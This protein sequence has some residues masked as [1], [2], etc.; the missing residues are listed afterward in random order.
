MNRIEI[1]KDKGQELFEPKSVHRIFN[2]SDLPDRECFAEADKVAL[3]VVTIGKNLPLEVNNLMESGEYVDGVILDAVGS[4]GVEAIADLINHQINKE[5]ERLHLEYSK[6]YSPGYC[7][8]NVKDQG[9]IFGLLPTKEIDVFLTDAY[10]MTP[11]K[12][13]SFAI[14]I[15]EGIKNSR[16]ENRCRSCED[17]GQC[18]YRLK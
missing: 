6:R 7:H 1:M 4:A 2:E 11:I 5:V 14:N 18:T 15:G 9:I 17:R 12:S 3:A 10:L 13:V 16:W 8:W